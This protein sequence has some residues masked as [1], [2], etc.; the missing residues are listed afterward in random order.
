MG[1]QWLFAINIPL[2]M[3]ALILALRTLPDARTATTGPFDFAGA[4]WSAMML[5]VVIMASNAFLMRVHRTRRH[6]SLQAF[7]AV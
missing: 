4:V 1:W 3:V 7:M 2:G 5:G 6:L